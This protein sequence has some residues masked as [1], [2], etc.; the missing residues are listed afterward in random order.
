MTKNILKV[1]GVTTLKNTDLKKVKGGTGPSEPAFPYT[2]WD[3]AGT[4]QSSFDISGGEVTCVRNS[5]S[6]IPVI[7]PKTR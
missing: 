2:C 3:N 1:N 5:I 7:S 4:F 6:T